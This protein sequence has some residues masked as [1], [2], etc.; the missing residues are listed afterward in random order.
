VEYTAEREETMAEVTETQLP[1]VGV[2]Y[3]FTTSDGQR[4]GVL[5]H[6]GGR[7]EIFVYDR[8]DPDA[9]STLLQLSADDTRTLSEL[10]GASQVTTGIAAAQ[11]QIEGLAIDWLRIPPESRFVGTTIGDGAFRTRTGVSIVAIVHGDT[12]VPAPGPEYRFEAGDFA[13][14]VGTPEGLGQLRNLLRE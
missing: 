13:V 9:A 2:R 8:R 12:T 1:G 11:Q 4:V 5:S 14:A 7:R 3:E 6:R 10:L